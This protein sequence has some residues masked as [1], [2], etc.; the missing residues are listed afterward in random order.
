VFRYNLKQALKLEA[1]GADYI[2]IGAV[3]PTLTKTNA[4]IVGIEGLQQIKQ[5]VAIPVVAIGGINKDNIR[6][7]ISAGADAVAVISAVFQ[8]DD[9]E[10]ATRQMVSKIAQKRNRNR[11]PGKNR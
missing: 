8:Q 10:K 1:E 3:Y 7:V 2:A 6:E 9:I 5:K 4:S 11:N